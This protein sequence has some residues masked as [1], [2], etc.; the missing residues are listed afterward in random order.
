MKSIFDELR[1]F[2]ELEPD[3]PYDV[4]ILHPLVDD[5]AI[6]KR[7]GMS[8]EDCT[9]ADLY[10]AWHRDVIFVSVWCYEDPFVSYRVNP[11]VRP[12]HYGYYG[13]SFNVRTRSC[14]LTK[15]VIVKALDFLGKYTDRYGASNLRRGKKEKTYVIAK[16]DVCA[17]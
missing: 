11:P 9:G 4:V 17:G 14:P 10:W 7:L 3:F 1:G 13:L 2:G 16:G 8:P 6:L 15:A 12:R 5:D